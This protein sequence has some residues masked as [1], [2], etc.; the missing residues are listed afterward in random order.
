MGRGA[1]VVNGGWGTQRHLGS[2]FSSAEMYF[3][4]GTWVHIFLPSNLKYFGGHKPLKE[5]TDLL[6]VDWEAHNLQIKTWL[7][8][9]LGLFPTT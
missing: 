7:K 6:L 4:V 1:R 2:I 9:Q 8:V 5:P 3:C